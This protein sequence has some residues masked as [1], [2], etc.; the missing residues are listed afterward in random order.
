MKPQKIIFILIF[1]I[2]GLSLYRCKTEEIILHGEISG[3]VTDAQTTLPLNSVAVKLNPVNDTIIT[4]SDG[5]Y[6]F[7]SLAPRDYLIQASKQNYAEG[8]KTAVVT[9]ANTDNINIALDEIPIIHYSTTTLD[10]GFNLTSLS[11]T[12]SKTG[13]GKVAYIISRSKDWIT[14]N[15]SPG[16]IDNETDTINV[17]INR[18]N[19]TQTFINEWIVI[20]STYL[21]YDFKDTINVNVN[22]HNPIIFNPSLSYGSVT[23]IDG[24]VYKTIVIGSQIWMAENLKTT[25]Y[26]NNT[27]IPLVV[28]NVVWRNLTTPGY[29][30]YNN[31]EE[32]Y[33]D[34]YG[35]LYNWNTVNT[36]KLCPIGWHVPL[37]AEVDTLITY[38]GGENVAGGKMKETGTTH[39]KAPNTEATN[40]SGFTGLPNSF[41]N[42]SGSFYPNGEQCDSWTSNII[43]YPNPPV[44]MI[45]FYDTAIGTWYEVLGQASGLSVR[46]VKDLSG[47]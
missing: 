19:L 34:I 45:L 41:R 25:K 18:T 30:W 46:C 8:T 35:A 2:I 43:Q 42:A 9:S 44:Y 10:F 40:S 11:F 38:L 14:A 26:N 27:P 6:L 23:D 13:T 37:F 20:R 33:K 32:T 7:K 16:D 39:W 36:G 5:K 4:G 12:I 3:I 22:V 21:Q 29:S 1:G 24:N 31:D 15:P 17:T 47:K 28:D